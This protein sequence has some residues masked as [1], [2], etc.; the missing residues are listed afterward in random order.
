MLA[1][2]VFVGKLHAVNALSA[3]AI[4]PREVTPLRDGGRQAAQPAVGSEDDSGLYREN[5]T[6]PRKYT[7][8][9]H[10]AGD[11]AMESASFE[12]QGHPRNANAFLSGAQCPKVLCRLW[13][14]IRQELKHNT[15]WLAAADHNIHEHA[16]VH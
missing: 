1:D 14:R 4:V 13:H 7:Y 10:E 2:K 5:T 12:V 8:L 16:W 9:A 3:R 6:R 15:A 11:D